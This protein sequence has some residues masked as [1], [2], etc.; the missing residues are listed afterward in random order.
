M[1][2]NLSL[3][4]RDR[5]ALIVGGALVA[6]LLLAG[7]LMTAGTVFG[8]LDRTIATRSA[9][10]RDL[11]QLRGEAQRLQQQIRLAEEKL[12][13]TAGGSQTTLIEG[14]ANRSAGQ[15]N[16]TYLR[17]LAASTQDGLTVETVE[18]KLER[19]SLGQVLRLLWEVEN[20]PAAAMRIQGLRL[21][22]RFENHALLDV[23]LTISAYRK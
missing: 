10:V 13:R 8:R 22:R 20:H 16:L 15:G 14:L 4:R 21:Q 17:P 7:G 6:L 11:D 19:Q 12:A 5:T 1:I 18:L 2:R 3:R 23:T 9:A